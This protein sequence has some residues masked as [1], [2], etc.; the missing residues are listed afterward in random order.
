MPEKTT[1]PQFEA[2]L[3]QL[4]QSRGFDFTGYKRTTLMRRVE[5][6]MQEVGISDFTDYSDFLEAHPDEFR[7]LFN[8]ILINVTSFFRDPE[9]WQTLAETVIKPLAADEGRQLRVWS[10]GCATGEETYTL[11]MLLA[12]AV[13]IE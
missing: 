2:L 13:G 9:A 3:S 5:K 4:K 6:R 1:N 11:V 12:E 8:T 10:A 7:S